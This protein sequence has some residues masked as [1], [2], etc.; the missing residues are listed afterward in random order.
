[1]DGPFSE[2]VT[3]PELVDTITTTLAHARAEGDPYKR[4]A[5]ALLG[6]IET[7][8]QRIALER[9]DLDV[10]TQHERTILEQ[11]EDQAE[12]ELHA[13][14]DKIWEHLGCPDYDPIYTVLFPS[15]SPGPHA[16]EAQAEQLSLAADL[17]SSGI[18]PKI[19]R[20]RGAQVAQEIRMMAERFRAHLL[21]LSKYQAR[22]TSL[23]ALEASVARIGLLEL[24]TLR[25]TLRSMGLDDTRIKFVVPAPVS[26]RRVP[27]KSGGY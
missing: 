15:R 22:Q 19:D 20:I 11:L 14:A 4:E 16:F 17:L 1:M 25:R 8:L 10:A 6:P 27:M 5:E 18:H 2:R 9:H 12:A 23:N 13:H 26:S 21:A 7:I 24:S 3:V